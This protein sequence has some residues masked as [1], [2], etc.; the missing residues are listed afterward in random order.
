MS[1]TIEQIETELTGDT[2]IPRQLARYKTWLSAVYSLRGGDMAKIEK[3]KARDWPRIRA[4]VQSVA[5]A[6][7]AWDATDDGQHQIDLKWQLRRIEKLISAINTRLRVAELE[8]RNI[9]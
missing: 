8:A 3:D 6:D 9:A 4:E 7:R 2:P 5:E 1:L